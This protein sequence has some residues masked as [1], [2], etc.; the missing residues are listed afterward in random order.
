MTGHLV[1]ADP[2][3]LYRLL[4]RLEDDGL[5]TSTWAEGTHG[6]QRRQYR[7]TAEGRDTLAQ[8]REHLQQQ[9]SVLRA[10]VHAIDAALNH[11]PPRQ[12]RP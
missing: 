6:P 8:W 12:D 3:G 7:V 2:G 4:R 9:A 5:V 11:N 1:P 10:I